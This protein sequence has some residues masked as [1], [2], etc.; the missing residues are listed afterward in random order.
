MKKPLYLAALASLFALGAESQ[1]ATYT[2]DGEVQTP[3][4]L[5]PMVTASSFSLS[6][7]A[8]LTFPAGND[9]T[10]ADGISAKG[11]NVAEGAK[12]WEF[13]ITPAPGH[14]LNL[15]SMT[16][17]D[18]RSSTGPLDWSLS[19]NGITAA[20]GLATHDTF[21][22]NPMNTVDLSGAEFQGVESAT[23]QLFG[24]S[25]SSSSG[26]WRLD[27]VTLTGAAVAVPEPRQ[28]PLMIC[29][30]LLGIGGYRRHLAHRC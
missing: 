29:L 16:F 28:Y 21:A 24:F 22:A 2:F 3:D 9:P 23:V 25:A 4:T 30:T 1:I 19:I 27:N 5:D 6:P 13:T 12:W 20:T 10:P 17:D 15:V 8:S 26:T 18:Q 14:L 7:S 11:W